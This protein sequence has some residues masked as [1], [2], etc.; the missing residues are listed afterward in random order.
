MA[1]QTDNGKKKEPTP[2]ADEK[3]KKKFDNWGWGLAW[4]GF[5]AVLLSSF[6]KLIKSTDAPQKNDYYQ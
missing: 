5:A 3:K 2:A 4:V 6:Y 1:K